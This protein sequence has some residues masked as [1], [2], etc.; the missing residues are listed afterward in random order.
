VINFFII[1]FPSS[2]NY[3]K[4]T[5]TLAVISDIDLLVMYA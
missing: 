2:A 5:K 3:A 1:S 4:C